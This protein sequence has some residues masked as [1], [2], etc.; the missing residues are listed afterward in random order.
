MATIPKFDSEKPGCE[1]PSVTLEETSGNDH[2]TVFG[3]SPQF[4]D[5]QLAASETGP[6]GFVPSSPEEAELSRR[7]NRK[8]D[9]AMLPL[10]SLVYLFN[11]LDK[12]NIGNAETQ[13]LSFA[14]SWGA[15]TI[16]QA[17]IQGRG[18]LIA[19]R[20]VIG[21]FEAGFYPTCVSYL[22]F[23]Y[24]RFDL[25]VRVAIFY[26][27]YAIAGAFSGAISFGVFHLKSG[28]LLNWQYLFII[29]GS[30]TCF[31]AILAFFLLPRGPGS[32]WFLTQQEREFAAERMR[33]DTALFI[34][35][36]YGKDG[37]EKDKLSRR[38]A[39]EAVKDWKFYGVI[40]FNICA[41]VPTQAFSIFL[42]LVLQG[43]GFA[44]IQANLMTVPP[45]VCGAVGLYIF[46]LSS[47]RRQVTSKHERGWHIIAS[48]AIGIIG[49]ILTVTVK[50]SGGKYA[51]LCILLFGCYVS[52][53]LTVAW[54][55]GNTPEP[56]KRTLILGA[57]GFG[58]L[59]GIIGSQI[60]AAKYGPSY[61]ISFYVTL[62]ISIVALLGY[63]GYRFAL[64]AA[65]RYKKDKMAR[66]TPEELERE[67]TDHTRYGDRKYTFIY[68]L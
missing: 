63:T 36:E 65:N 11:G 52:A 20:L 45:Y 10:L 6:I 44:S 53:P 23:F 18:S 64:A 56:G 66:M 35:H 30:L 24:G 26:G 49:L 60:F 9:F 13:D 19:I 1:S 57:N 43:L 39:I 8:M 68:G 41:S 7:V 37:M 22:S 50:A 5:S 2:S 32:A 17:F 12:G 3:K 29:E 62:G 27:Q 55:S 58:N 33:R 42:P 21:L 61:R 48:I 28:S 40:I 31:V 14:F 67:R 54:L 34:L 46:A 4:S 51:G 16:G 38:D 25:A 15:L 47:D 59:A